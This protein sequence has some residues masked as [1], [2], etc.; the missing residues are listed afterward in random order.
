MS[1]LLSRI[2]RTSFRHRRI[3]VAVWVVALIG[4]AIASSVAGGKLTTEFRI[5]GTESQEALDKLQQKMPAMGAE[6]A[7][8]RLVFSTT[9]GKAFSGADRQFVARSVAKVT[10]TENVVNAS[11]PFKTG[12]VSKDGSIAFSVVS[13]SKPADA[14]LPKDQDHVAAAA[15]A[16]SAAG[17]STALSSTGSPRHQ[18]EGIPPE[19]IGVAIAVL[20]LAITFGSMLAAGLPLLSALIGVG[21]GLTGIMLLS[22][23]VDLSESVISIAAMLG[24]AVGIDYT[25]FIL[26]RHR[27]QAHAGMALEDSAS[28]AVGTAGSAVVFAGGTVIIALAALVVTGV[29]FLAWMG[30]CAALTVLIAVLAAITF[31][32]AML[33]F[34]G[35]RAVKGKRF[36]ENDTLAGE[37]PRMGARWVD[38]VL[39]H[40]T[41]AVLIPI[42]LTLA[43]AIPATHMRLGLPDD[44]SAAAGSQERIAY[45]KVAQGFGPGFSGPLVVVAEPD[46]PAEAKQVTGALQARLGKYEDVALAV[47]VGA[48]PDGSI[49]ILSAIPKSGPSTK[50]TAD[51]VR[52]IRADQAALHREL[53]ASVTLTGQTALNI[54]IADRMADS[55]PLYLAV[56]VGLALLL[57][58]IAFRSL[59]VPLTAVGG[60]LLTI[61]ASFGAMVAIFQDGFAASLFGVEAAPVVSLLPILVIGI[62]FGL[63]MDYQVFLVSR[64]HE[65]HAHGMSAQ[66]AIHDGFAHSARV[67]TAAGLIMISVFASFILTPEPIVKSVGFALTFGIFVDAFLVRMTLI[68]ALM[69]FMGRHAWYLPRWMER[70]VPDVDL[71]GRDLEREFAAK[72]E[73]EA[74]PATA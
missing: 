31:V 61:A 68:P 19:L 47:P 13:F 36:D 4:I 23:I 27:T 45:D 7:S 73:T 1:T 64:M 54:D 74:V 29:P 59:L 57:L 44:S 25:L 62:L 15:N 28:L 43:V 70:V 35:E 33:G 37:K 11:D 51:L 21:I 22:A 9:S 2:G 48:S 3:V 50:Q 53:G 12:T 72:L 30:I 42:A 58:L 34:A 24:L 65:A 63:A 66:D 60:F 49:V 52:A 38:L 17:V 8:A 14:L 67:V 6:N 20:V 10:K 46:N 56:V 18:Q 5:P 16:R 40:R 69:S 26:S 71:E 32:P 55:L 41:W 39:R